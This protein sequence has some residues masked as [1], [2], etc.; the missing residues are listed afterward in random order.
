[1]LY[2]IGDWLKINGEAIYGTRPFRVAAEG[3]AVISD[4]SF[5]IEKQKAQIDDG[6]AVD[7]SKLELGSEDFRFTHN[8]ALYAIALGWPADGKLKIKSLK[9]G[10]A[11]DKITA[12]SLLGNEGSLAF[13]QTNDALEI[14]LPP[15]KPC[16]HAFALKI[17]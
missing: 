13:T 2:E 15:N 7:M 14:T 8:T 11:L 16:E 12:V 17:V 9:T 4:E 5:D 6:M 1:M 10:G 3:P